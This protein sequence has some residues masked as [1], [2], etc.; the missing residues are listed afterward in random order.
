MSFTA[1]ARRHHRRRNGS[2]HDRGGLSYR[3]YSVEELAEQFDV[4]RGG[5]SDS[6]R[7]AAQADELKSFQPAAVRQCCGP[8]A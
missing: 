3:G 8:W 1:R 2:E 4:R 7:R 5:L 6:V